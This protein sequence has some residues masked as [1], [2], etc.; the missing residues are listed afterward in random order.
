MPRVNSVG[1]LVLTAAPELLAV[2]DPLA[3]ALTDRLRR[4]GPAPTARLSIELEAAEGEVEARLDELEAVGIVVRDEGAWRAL[5][6]GFVFE[7]PD[8]PDGQ[9]AA[10]RLANVMY[11]QY[12]DLPRRW[13]ADDEPRLELDWARAAGLFNAG[14]ALT[15]DELRSVQESLEDLLAPYLTREADAVPVDAR[16]VR[17]LAYFMPEPASEEVA[18]DSTRATARTEP[19]TQNP[20]PTPPSDDETASS[21]RSV[22]SIGSR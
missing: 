5:G 15:P 13:V 7:I 22:R 12:V 19:S 17:V 2:A 1:D 18:S 4:G 20:M 16:R 3:L 9:A 10:R 21:S 11:L 8:D 6:K 14:V